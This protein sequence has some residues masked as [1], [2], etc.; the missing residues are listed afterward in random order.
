LFPVD[1][2]LG[3]TLDVIHQP[4]INFFKVMLML[5]V[6]IITDFIGIHLTGNVYGVTIATAFTIL[7]GIVISFYALN[8]YYVK[9]TI[10]DIYIR[11]FKEL[12]I[13]YSNSF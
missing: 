6:T 4:K 13:L 8:L 10:K 9:F 2:F 12:K 1:R 5:L 7:T 11:G 3:L